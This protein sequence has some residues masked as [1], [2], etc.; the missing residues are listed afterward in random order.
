MALIFDIKR[1]SINDGPG[2]RTTIFMKGCPLRC[3]W[4]HNPEGLQSDAQFLFTSKKCIG[5]DTC[6]S[7]SDEEAA[8]ECPTRARQISGRKWP[9]DE[10]MTVVEKERKVMEDSGGGVTISGGEPFMHVDYL[11]QLLTELGHRGF[12]R[13]VDTSLFTDE[14][15]VR[16][17]AEVSELFLVDLKVMDGNLHRQF[18]GVPNEMIH[19]NL[20]VLSSIGHPYWIRVPMIEGVNCTTDNMERSAEF[21]ASLNTKP[22]IVNL[23]PYHNIGLGKL[24]K[25]ATKDRAIIGR[26][27]AVPSEEC[28]MEFLDIFKGHGL[29]AIIGG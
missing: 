5:C 26:E 27:F 25:L 14:Q 15:H 17:V 12:H 23:L 3:Q 1:F 6:K 20:T 18:T 22:E 9:M 16:Q 24:E 29:N 28:Q 13:T 11:L 4:C 2:I 19:H 10:L 7:L 21:L 8:R